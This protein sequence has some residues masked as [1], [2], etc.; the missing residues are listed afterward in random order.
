MSKNKLQ[1]NYLKV[2]SDPDYAELF[3]NHK[4][5]KF[6]IDEEIA[7]QTDKQSERF[8][9]AK[10]IISEISQFIHKFPTTTATLG[11]WHLKNGNIEK[12]KKYYSESISIAHDKGLKQK[13]KA[14]MNL[15]L[16]KIYFKNN[17]FEKTLSFLKKANKTDKEHIFSLE[18][19]K[20]EKKIK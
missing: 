19:S 8:E 17:D 13:L 15:E 20:L 4:N 14:K 7:K 12:G 3:W 18:I 10:K 2:G 11:L 1:K 16:A 6:E 9:K 5:S